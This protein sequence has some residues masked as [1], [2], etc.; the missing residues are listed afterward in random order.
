MKKMLSLWLSMLLVLLLSGCAGLNFG[1]GPSVC[2]NVPPEDSLICQKIPKPETVDV[3]L[4]LA[5]LE[6][7]K[8]DAYTAAQA[9]EFIT[10]CIN[11]LETVEDWD[12]LITWITLQMEDVPAEIIILSRWAPQFASGGVLLPMDRQMLLYHLNNQLQI[13]QMMAGR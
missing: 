12:D 5:N 13:V 10:K 9:E 3:L 11:F 1:G 8:Y 2:D 7:I 4:Q 6:G